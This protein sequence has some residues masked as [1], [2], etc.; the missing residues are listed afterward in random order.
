MNVDVPRSIHTE[1]L[2]G[3]HVVEQFLSPGQDLSI[4]A[5]SVNELQRTL[6]ASQTDLSG[7]VCNGLP[8][9]PF[10]DDDDAVLMENDPKR[11]I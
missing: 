2:G 11:I 5:Q 9:W 8:L 1:T 6:F 4:K 3:D 7:K 10:L